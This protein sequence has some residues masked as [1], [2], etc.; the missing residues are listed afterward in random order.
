MDERSTIYDHFPTAG[1][2]GRVN[3]RLRVGRTVLSGDT[4]R[5]FLVAIVEFIVEANAYKK[6]SIPFTTTGQNYL[7]AKMP[8]HPSGRKFASF[9]KV[10]FG[11]QLLYLNTNHPPFFAL[12]MGDRLLRAAGFEPSLLER[13]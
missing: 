4:V 1:H 8:T 12:R 5:A 6:I 9:A 3:L 7:L 13:P 10:K 11:Q 2:E